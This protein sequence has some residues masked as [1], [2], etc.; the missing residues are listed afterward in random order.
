M[1]GK[2]DNISNAET[3]PEINPKVKTVFFIA[4]APN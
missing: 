4:G 3:A 1:N 2:V